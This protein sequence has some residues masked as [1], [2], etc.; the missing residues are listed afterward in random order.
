M[1]RKFTPEYQTQ[2]VEAWKKFIHYEDADYSFIRPEILESWERSRAAGVSP[3]NT[4][5]E[6]LS[7]E[8]LTIRIN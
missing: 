7:S 1:H 6:I 8:E 3:Y 5:T 4:E 2:L